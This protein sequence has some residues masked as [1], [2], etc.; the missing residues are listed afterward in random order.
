MTVKNPHV[1]PNYGMVS[2]AIERR[3]AGKPPA[4]LKAEDALENA[5]EEKPAKSVVSKPAR[6]AK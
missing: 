4:S 3:I 1:P 5:A 6:K 2:T